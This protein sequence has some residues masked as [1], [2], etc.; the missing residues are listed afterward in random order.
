MQNYNPNHFPS[1]SNTFF[2]NHFSVF[3]W[4]SF[5]LLIACALQ[6]MVN[7]GGDT[8]YHVAVG[9]LIRKYGILHAF[10]WT[11]FSWLAD[12]YTDDKLLFHLMFVPLSGIPWDT[13]A[14]IVG[15]LAGSAILIA[16]YLILRAERVR[17]P[18]L[19]TF[20]ALASSQYF[21][22][23]FLLVRPHLLSITL[24]LI[25]LWAASRGKYAILATVSAIYP[26]SYVAFW[27]LPSLLLIAAEAARLLAGERVRW[28]P[29]VVTFGGIAVG[30]AIHPNA[31]NLL[32][33]NWIVMSEVLF[34]AG[35]L[36]KTGLDM[37]IELKPYPL[38]GWALGLTINVFMA[39]AAGMFAW[40]NRKK[41][42][43]LLAFS[44]ASLC[45]FILTVKSGR[46]LEYFVPFSAAA[47][48][49]ASR[50]IGW[51]YLLPAIFCVSMV[52]TVG[53]GYPV[54]REL[55]NEQKEM[56]PPIASF[57][58]QQIPPGSQVFTTTWDVTGLLLVT[59]P[60]RYFL[61]ALDPTL[62][63]LKDPDLYRFWYRIIRKAPPGLA[64]TIREKFGARFV[65]V[66]KPTR[67]KAFNH[68]LSKE[69]GVRLL[70]MTERWLLFDLGPRTQENS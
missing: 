67:S 29:A 12:S 58:Q 36:G 42:V 13:A 6:W 28:K 16:L 1:A 26:W 50:F 57:F 8:P 14:R 54:A 51:R 47:M 33:Y 34:K 10:P 68:Q 70:L 19:W 66:D 32:E 37:G 63:Y 64:K 22:Y 69:P 35:W 46:F 17:S 43:V 15:S 30:V 59:L 45:F 21:I 62:F 41:D 40:T 38:L 48:A 31:A 23:R 5:Y 27:Q 53:L 7:P 24:A 52:Y 20:I 39:I 18:G 55:L 25:F 11:P 3:L 61:V 44:L 56:P 49:L 4:F 60:E 2:K 9:H 65:V